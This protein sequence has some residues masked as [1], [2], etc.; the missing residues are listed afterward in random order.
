MGQNLLEPNI[1]PASAGIL[2]Q[3]FN[4]YKKIPNLWKFVSVEHGRNRA[5]VRTS[6]R[7]KDPFRWIRIRVISGSGFPAR[8][9][10][11]MVLLAPPD[12]WC[13]QSRVQSHCTRLPRLRSVRSASPTREG[14]LCWLRL[15]L[16]C[17]SWC[18]CNSKGF[19]CWLRFWSPNCILFCP[20]PPRE[21]LELLHWV[22]LLFLQAHLHFLIIFLKAFI[23]QDGWNQEEPRPILGD[24]TLKELYGISISSSHEVKY[25]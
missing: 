19:S 16:Q 9:P 6:K 17:S 10:G 4:Y 11:N 3:D 14:S 23:F 7:A 13:S 5:Q 24:S 8:V 25:Q 20:S 15:W 21:S 12:D 18:S 2:L 22:Y 1:P